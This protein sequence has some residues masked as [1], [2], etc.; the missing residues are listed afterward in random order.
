MCLIN[1]SRKHDDHLP[2]SRRLLQDVNHLRQADPAVSVYIGFLANNWGPAGD[3][4]ER[5][6]GVFNIPAADAVE[7]AFKRK[8]RCD[9]LVPVDHNLT[10]AGT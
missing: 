6:D 9:S 1:A 5:Q 10:Y 2:H 3:N 4:L 8:G 7:I